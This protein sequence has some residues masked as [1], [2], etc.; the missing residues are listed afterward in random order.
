MSEQQRT[1]IGSIGEFGLIDRI[2]ADLEMK[3]DSTIKGVGDDAAVI[4][5]GG[6]SQL[7]S[8]DIM[9]EGIHFDL[10]YA[11]LKHVGY[12]AV[13][14]NLSD[15][16]AM[17]AQPKQIVVSLAIS[18]RFSV[19]AVEELYSGVKLACERYEVDLIGG[20][21]TAS[22]KGLIINVTVIGE[23]EDGKIVYRNGA[24]EGDLLCVSGDL[25][26]AYLGLQLLEREKQIFKEHPTIKP[27]LE[28]HKYLVER[29]LKPE[30]R[31]GIVADLEEFGIVPN[32]MI[33]ISDG[34]SSEIIHLCKQSNVGC[35]LEEDSIPIANDTYNQALEFNIGP[36]MCALSGGEDYE[37]L[38]AVDPKW[39]EKIN[40]HPD[41]VVIGEFVDAMRGVKLHTKGDNYH[42]LVSM[43]WNSLK[44]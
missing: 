13:V 22:N 31:K 38:F 1:E 9:V 41:I 5:A 25:G 32:A 11:P 8:T 19:E 42:D 4:N 39:E 43:G 36:T 35:Q 27:D 17:N 40:N 37:L 3:Q 20:D 18:N 24:K 14:T 23:Q 34:L 44:D 26:A 29:Q 7:V 15:I 21:T 12:K 10:A 6:K 28:K 16:Y 33:D 30:A 2:T